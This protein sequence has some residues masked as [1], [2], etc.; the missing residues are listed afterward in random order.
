M[1]L[2]MPAFA[3]ISFA[4]GSLTS[5]EQAASFTRE[6]E[7]AWCQNDAL[8]LCIA[9]VPD[10]ARVATC[11]KAKRASLSPDCRKVFTPEPERRRS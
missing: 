8:R 6:Q 2:P 4:V 7:A 3:L 1:N 5:L 11:L 10:E 9:E